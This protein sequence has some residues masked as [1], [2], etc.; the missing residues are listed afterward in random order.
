MDIIT[1]IE[2]LGI[3]MVGYYLIGLAAVWAYEIKRN[4][5]YRQMK[6][7]V[8]VLECSRFSMALTHAK[9][10]KITEDYRRMA[11][12]LERVQQFILKNVLLIGGF[13]RLSSTLDRK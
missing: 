9:T 6:E 2:Y 8:K 4:A 13:H 7:Q 1:T 3:V 5:L 11:S 12:G 10:Y